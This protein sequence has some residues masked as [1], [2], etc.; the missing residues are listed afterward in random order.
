MYVVS[1]NLN[2]ILATN[3]NMEEQEPRE[4]TVGVMTTLLKICMCHVRAWLCAVNSQLKSGPGKEDII[5][6]RRKENAKLK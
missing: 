1:H 6:G 5:S 2:I 4:P 3:S